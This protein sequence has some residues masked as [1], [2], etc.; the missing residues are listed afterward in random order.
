MSGSALL[1]RI[2]AG[3][4]QVISAPR[5][6]GADDQRNATARPRDRRTWPGDDRRSVAGPSPVRHRSATGPSPVRHRSATGPS[7]ARCAGAGCAAAVRR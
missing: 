2:R 7:P 6:P 4:G 3:G 5:G 1:I